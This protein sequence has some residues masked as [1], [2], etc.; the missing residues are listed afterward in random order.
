MIVNEAFDD[1]EDAC[2]EAFLAPLA[3]VTPAS[4]VN[5]R[6]RAR[7]RVRRIVI[8]VVLVIGLGAGIAVA[9]GGRWLVTVR[10]TNGD[11]TTAPATPVPVAPPANNGCRDPGCARPGGSGPAGGTRHHAGALRRQHTSEPPGDH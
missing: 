10:D 8:L 7:A 11:V 2:V 4:R 1:L 5:G 3:G 6:R 9:S